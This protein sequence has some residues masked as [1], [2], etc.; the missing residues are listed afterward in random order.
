MGWRKSEILS[1][2]IDASEDILLNVM[3]Y[4]GMKKK[5]NGPQVKTKNILIKYRL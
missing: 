3:W 4:L 2:F 1:E 5:K